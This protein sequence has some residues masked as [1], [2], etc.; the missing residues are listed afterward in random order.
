LLNALQYANSA[1][2][3]TDGARVLT[4]SATDDN[5]NVSG[6]AQAT[7]LV[8]TSVPAIA[9]S[10]PL[11]STDANADGVKGDQFT[12]SFS[13]MVDVSRVTLANL[14]LSAGS[15]GTGAS[16]AALNP[17][18]IGSTSYA[19]QFVVTAGTGATYTTGATLTMAAANV[20]DTGGATAAGNVVFTMSDIVA[21][22]AMTPPSSISGNYI[23]AAEKTAAATTPITAAFTFTG[24]DSKYARYY[25]NGVELS[26][27]LSTLASASATTDTLSLSASDLPAT[28][29]SYI[30]TARLED[31]AGNLGPVSTSKLFVLDTVLASN[32]NSVVLLDSNSNGA[33]DAGETV[34]VVFNELVKLTSSSTGLP[35]AFGTGASAVAV[36]PTNGFSSTWKVTLG[37]S[38][39]LT[40]GGTLLFKGVTDV[41][42]NGST[43]TAVSA[44]NLSVTAPTDVLSSPS[45]LQMGSVT[46]DNVINL[47]ERSASQSISL[48]LSGARTGDTV[49]LYMDGVLLGSKVIS[50]A[51]ASANAVSLSIAANAWGADGERVLSSTIERTGGTV[52]AAATKRFVSVAADG[53]H[54]SAA[55]TNGGSNVLWFDPETLT[56]N[57]NVG[58]GSLA[59]AGTND[60][61]ASVGGSRAYA[62]TV[63]NQPLAVISVNG[64]LMLSMNGSN[65]LRMTTPT[66]N[67]PSANNSFY[68]A[69][70][71]N[72][73][74]DQSIYRWLGGIGLPG[75]SA[76]TG[77]VMGQIGSSL[78]TGFFDPQGIQTANAVSNFVNQ[79]VGFLGV[80]GSGGTQ[81]GQPLVNSLVV[82]T[83]TRSPN[84]LAKSDSRWV[85]YI[86]ATL[87]GN[88]G[89]QGLIGDTIY[90]TDTVSLA[91]RQEVDT[92]LAAKYITAG[93]IVASTS[94][95][96]LL[97][98]IST[99]NVYDLSTSGV[100]T[101]IIDQILDLR[102]SS[103]AGTGVKVLTSGSD[104]VATGSGD[105]TVYVKDL[106]FRYI[107]AGTGKDTLVLDSSYTAAGT[108]VLAD[109]VSN[110]RG[111]SGVS[112]DDSRVNAAGYHK[113]MGFEK[114]DLS[115][116]SAAQALSV[117]KTDVS[118]LADV[119]AA[120]STDTNAHTLGVV[121]GSNDSISTTGFASNT[122]V[123]GYYSFNATVYDQKWSDT[124]GQT[125]N[126]LETLILYARGTHFSSVT[127]TGFAL[128]SGATS[129]NDTLTGTTGN[130]VL[131]GGQGNDSLTGGLGADIFRF[132]KGDLGADTVADFSKTLGDKVDLS[133]LLQGSAFNALSNLSTYLQ[134]STDGS[135]N[136]VL[137]VDTYGES[138]FASPAQTI[139]FANAASSGLT[140]VTLATL[141]D[142]RVIV[143]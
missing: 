80:Q 57:V 70:A 81:T 125:G 45:I 21:P 73:L 85:G 76:G 8:N 34:T 47:A 77:F 66:A 56:V 29:G 48:S 108:I 91:W 107:D 89:Y 141:F 137:K 3:P 112:A 41:A 106:A 135:G 58:Q 5:S 84:I 140:G 46:T 87:N 97:S 111:I 53:V 52:Q 99:N 9:A 11:V 92:Y 6:N 67:M 65:A 18:T 1:G 60:Y 42:G 130:D 113:L 122:P 104:W 82:N 124:N 17:V 37:T 95:G 121:L 40:G 134:L 143:A 72:S 126:S 105:D 136:A 31:T 16:I 98:G 116:S 139:V 133:G 129:G 10:S 24:T 138:N 110:S 7:V 142:E 75:F 93:S 127:P 83:V 90:I 61:Y 94:N 2:T 71:S 100:R 117:A 79:T 23:N 27:K 19:R 102:A 119:D 55:S 59:S 38:P 25:I 78:Y 54:W 20:V 118:Q 13:E 39:S 35:A 109:F 14:A 114:I 32:A 64:R 62:P 101:V 68:A 132:A 63:G 15:Y 4:L 43:D 131:Q 88:E 128:V 44:G 96:V 30:L 49:K 12:L 69:A 120:N 50:A 115:Q 123:W 36:G 51:E 86:G 103:A 26:S 33:G 22:G 28:D 74:T